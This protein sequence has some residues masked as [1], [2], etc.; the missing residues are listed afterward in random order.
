MFSLFIP[1]YYQLLQAYKPINYSLP[2]PTPT[3]TQILGVSTIDNTTTTLPA[4][5]GE[6]KVITLALF[7]DSMIQTLKN[8][9][10]EKSFQKYF[11]ATKFNL[12]NFGYSSTNFEQAFTNLDKII[13]SNPDL[14]VIESFAYNNFGNTATG[15]QKQSQLLDQTINI[16]K[17]K[18]SAKVILAATIA[19]NSVVFSNGIPNLH[20]T[21]LEKLERAKTIKLY[22][23]NIIKY[24]Q[25]NRLPLANSYSGSLVNNEGFLPLI[26]STD[27]LHPSDYGIEFFGDTLAKT[28]FDSKLI[29]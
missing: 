23:E 5:G 25:N 12:L 21:S 18:T 9:L 14:I 28:I 26:S 11:P 1:L 20:L 27:H 17:Q 7:G 2:T 19:P 8:D 29:D 6:G 16:I 24:S 10:L 13:S 3:A 22:L 15:L 4:V